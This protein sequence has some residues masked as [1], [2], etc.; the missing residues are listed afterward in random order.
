MYTLE[1][2]NYHQEDFMQ[3]LPTSMMSF[4]LHINSL[5]FGGGYQSRKQLAQFG[6]R[7]REEQA[8]GVFYVQTLGAQIFR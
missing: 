5:L 4:N 6:G 2:K 8:Y 1:T 3:I 7:E